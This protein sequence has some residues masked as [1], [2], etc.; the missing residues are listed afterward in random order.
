MD[1]EIIK[2]ARARVANALGDKLASKATDAFCLSFLQTLQPLSF[3]ESILPHV[4]GGTVLEFTQQSR[5]SAAVNEAVESIRNSPDW[6]RF[7]NVIKKLDLSDVSTGGVTEVMEAGRSEPELL[8]LGTARLLRHLKIYALKDNF[9]KIAGPITDRLERGATVGVESLTSTSKSN[10]LTEVCWLNRTVYST[11]T[12]QALAVVA[13]DDSIHSIDLPRRIIPE[14]NVSAFTVGAPQFRNKFKRTGKGIIVAVID[15]E[16]ALTHPALKGRVVHKFNFSN[17]PWDNPD[18]HG[19]AVAGIIGSN[20]STFPGMATAATI[21]NYKILPKGN[22]F[23]GS[24]AIQQALTDGAHIANCSWGAGAAGD[25]TSREA[26]ACDEAWKAGLTIVKSAGNGGPDPQTCTTPADAD[27]VIVVGA[28]EREGHSVQDYSSRG[29]AGTKVRP[30]LIAPGGIDGGPGITSSLTGGGFGDT[31]AGTSY[32]APHVS[33]VL[34]LL[35]E[36][37]PSLTPDELR[38][39]LL[40]LST[41]LPGVDDNT[42]G[43]GLFSLAGVN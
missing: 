12:A 1:P 43:R 42:E 16:V 25:G 39:T 19:T 33:G 34:A 28:T 5:V 41:S 30:H 35:L 40:S 17:E 6:K 2:A 14:I 36:R 9:Y 23:F 7:R 24:L 20:D 3:V 37:D 29:P 22:D 15:G 11:G 27:G 4:A 31:G 26:R 8:P 21:Y 13:A 38:D 32:A 10:P 18:A